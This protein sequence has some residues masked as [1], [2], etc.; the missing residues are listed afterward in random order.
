MENTISIT[1]A[2]AQFLSRVGLNHIIGKNDKF[3]I[4]S[5]VKN[6][7]DLI[8]CLQTENADVLIIDFDQPGYFSFQTLQKVK[9][10]FPNTNILLISSNNDKPSIYQ[11]LESGVNSYLT[12]TCGEEEIEDAIYATAKGEKFYC[13]KIIDY[14]LEKSFASPKAE[15]T[16]IPLSAREI[17]I[18][19]LIAKGLIAKEI[20]DVLNLS[21]HT[22][23]TH[24]KNIM[25]KLD[26]SSSSEL[27]LYALNNGL[28]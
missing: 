28:I 26:I 17:E 4:V 23:Y 20:A 22:I 12:K 8:N 1:V 25:K 21:T 27:I 10:R 5:Q 11:V 24:R 7:K 14:L 19:R 2:D 13:T 9:D 16:S 6:E 15:T 18:L 3:K